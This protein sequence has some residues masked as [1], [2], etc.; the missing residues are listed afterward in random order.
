MCLYMYAVL[1]AH[2]HLVA[3][4]RFCLG[5]GRWGAGGLGAERPSAHLAMW[6]FCM[7]RL[8]THVTRHGCEFDERFGGHA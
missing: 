7:H 4:L 2:V 1:I 6:S 5:F 3:E 8:Y